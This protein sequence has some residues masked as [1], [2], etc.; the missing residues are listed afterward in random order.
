MKI[1]EAYKTPNIFLRS[2][3]LLFIF[4]SSA[5]NVSQFAVTS[6]LI[7]AAHSSP[8]LDAIISPMPSVNLVPST[9]LM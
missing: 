4:F 6:S 5:V 3:K 1:M 9:I 2:L 7:V 8:K